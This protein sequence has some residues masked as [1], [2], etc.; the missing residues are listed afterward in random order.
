MKVWRILKATGNNFIDNEALSRGA[1]IA[2]YTATSLAPVLLIVVAITGL[3]FGT[4]VARDSVT[5]QLISLVGPRGADFIQSLVISQSDPTKGTVSTLLGLI[6]ILVT[7]SG[8][9]GEMRA[10]LNKTWNVPAATEPVSALIHARAASLG[11][12]GALAFSVVVSLA[13]SAA[14]SAVGKWI[15]DAFPFMEVLLATLNTLISIVL[16]SLLFS[17]IYK[18][19]PDRSLALRDVTTGGITTAIL[20]TA[21]KS[22]IGWYL[23]AAAPGSAD[24]AAGALIVLMLW[25]Y[26]S[27]QI[28]LFGAE[29]T[30][31]ISDEC[32]EFQLATVTPEEQTVSAAVHP[33]NTSSHQ[34]EPSMSKSVE[35][36]RREAEQS[37]VELAST[38]EILRDRIGEKTSPDNIKT[39]VREYIAD[40][41]TGWADQLKHQ[42]MENPLQAL[43][44]GS[45][46][47]LPAL[48]LVRAVPLPMLLVGAGFALC[49]TKV[50]SK[51]SGALAP[52]LQPVT[53]FLGDAA[54]RARGLG[55][56]ARERASDLSSQAREKLRD[57]HGT[58]TA[59]YDTARDR[60]TEAAAN[61]QPNL[62]QAKVAASNA[63]AKASEALAA[64][65][66]TASNFIKDNAALI[67]GLGVAIGALVAASLPATRAE[68]KVTAT[69]TTGARRAAGAAARSGIDAA[70]AVVVS[71]AEAATETVKDADL[72]GH[73]SRMAGNL[74]ETL[75]TVAADAV[76]TA[77]DPSHN[78]NHSEEAGHE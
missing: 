21:G 2:F 68:A 35:Q 52:A 30:K 8:V 33:E 61:I 69:A 70:K 3:V 24:G 43:A 25:T 74:A 40:K 1:A 27:A 23:G 45:A 7:A 11:L 6:M 39:E 41:T 10:A 50:R 15:G 14:L 44:V 77:F 75:K 5:S 60:V 16:F 34:G 54:D 13:A 37:R 9:F 32:R 57:L 65:P 58:A 59:A 31:A 73:A 78:P 62:D 53:E 66:V 51:A 20:F 47:A 56:D 76:T 36:L 4:D 55:D 46:I 63:R 29:L 48:R 19:L 67:G 71:A 42:A 38:V 72:P 49:S 17:A 22:L 18:V 64:A 12:V 28:F 26:Y